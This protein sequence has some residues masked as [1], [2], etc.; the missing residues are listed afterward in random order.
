VVRR[1]GEGRGGKGE[2][3]RVGEGRG[4]GS[5]EIPR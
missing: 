4:K 2:E 5:S 3:R 1:V